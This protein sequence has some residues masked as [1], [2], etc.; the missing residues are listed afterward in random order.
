MALRG[1]FNRY[2]S[3]LALLAAVLVAVPSASLAGDDVGWPYR[4]P[5]ELSGGGSGGDDE[6]DEE[7]DSSSE[8]GDEEE[9]EDAGDPTSGSG[10]ATP[11]AKGPG[12]GGKAA[13]VDGT[14]LWSWWWEHNKDR[15]LARATER[16]RVNAGSSLYWFG[17]GAKFPPRNLTR[18][19]DDQRRKI[20]NV[21]KGRLKA[22]KSPSVRIAAL[23]ALGRLGNIE[24][25]EKELK[26][27]KKDESSNLCARLLLASAR[28]KGATSGERNAALLGLGLTGDQKA[29]MTLL[30][31]LKE[32]PADNRPSAL[33]AFGLARVPEAIHTLALSIPKTGN[34]ASE[35]NIA[36]IMALGLYGPAFADQINS[37][38]SY[39]RN[40]L[41]QIAKLAVGNG[42]K[43]AVACQ[44]LIT[45][46]RLQRNVAAVGKATKSKSPSVKYGAILALAEFS[47]DEDT[48]SKAWKSLKKANRGS[49]QIQ[50]FVILS[51]GD[52]A[53]RLGANSATRKDILKT[54][55]GKKFLGSNDNYTRACTVI[56]L[57]VAQDP[58][59]AP[60]IAALLS[61]TTIDHYV[62]GACSVALGL[63]KAAD[64]ADLVLRRVVKGKFNADS[65]GYGLI[66]L[67][68]MGD[69]TRVGEVLKFTR[70]KQKETARQVPLAIGVLGSGR[71]SATLTNYF[72]QKWGQSERFAASSA[73]F[74]QSWIRDASSVDSL[75]KLASSNGVDEV[76]AMAAIALGYVGSQERISGLTR[77][78]A[79]S[80]Y[81]KSFDGFKTLKL[82]SQIL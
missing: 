56:A 80:N 9:D 38:K 72:K 6:E 4:G 77:C 51:A 45:L 5:S 25:N 71:Q 15:F 74:G 1:L 16:G 75:S 67:A 57:G 14:I 81:R 41:D 61:N 37:E 52:L 40:A 18:V 44:S 65:K 69:T 8:E 47:G 49:K 46:A 2:F 73:V 55:T 76:R 39:G 23:I 78:F 11:T 64:Q 58:T 50:N 82:I 31:I 60:A 3:Y 24:A 66:G 54:L 63:L 12:S 29:C 70:V 33:V 20:F 28:R 68:L 22:D 34:K 36:A 10:S 21:L 79:N 7:D 43:V 42:T 13:S 27:A 59:A 48:A 32:V 30:R 17:S 35:T 19:S 53:S 26:D 62:A